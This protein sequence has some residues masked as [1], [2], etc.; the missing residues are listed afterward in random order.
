MGR[1]FKLKNNTYLDYSTIQQ[2][3]ITFN[4]EW[5][6]AHQVYGAGFRMVIPFNN[7]RGKYPTLSLTSCEYFGGAGWES[8][9]AQ[10][11]SVR[12]NEIDIAF[13][14]ITNNP[15]QNVLIRMVGTLSI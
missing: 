7:P 12:T 10:L 14:G 15:T 4:N 5:R 11:G 13:N 6:Y 3:T 8:I 1:T 9:T 2:K